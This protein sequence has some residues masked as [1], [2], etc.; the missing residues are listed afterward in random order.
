MLPFDHALVKPDKLRRLNE[1]GAVAFQPAR[2]GR[3]LTGFRVLVSRQVVEPKHHQ[4]VAI[5]K[6]SLVDRLPETGLVHALENCHGMAGDFLSNALEAERGNV[7]Q[8]ERPS[9]T[10]EKIVG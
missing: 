8:L 4:R 9:D 10:L 1:A 6:D 2:E 5:G 3:D 7:E